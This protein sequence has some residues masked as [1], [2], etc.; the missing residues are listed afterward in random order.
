MTIIVMLFVIYFNRVLDCHRKFSFF[1]GTKKTWAVYKLSHMKTIKDKV[2]EEE[3]KGINGRKATMPLKITFKM[4]T[5]KDK[6]K[7][8][9]IKGINGRKATMPLKV[10]IKVII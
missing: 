6:V 5:I 8:E 9:E 7:E 3:I 10:M 4:K 1:V 2:K